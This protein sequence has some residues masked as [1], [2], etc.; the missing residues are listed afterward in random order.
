MSFEALLRVPAL[1][2]TMWT[3][4]LFAVA[5]VLWLLYRKQCFSI[6]KNMGVP[7]P[8]PS[9][10]FGNML[11]LIKKDPIKSIDEWLKKYGKIVGYYVGTKPVVL[12][13]D[14]DLLKR[15]QVSE[16]HKFVNRANVVRGGPERKTGKEKRV[17]GFSQ[18]LVALRD[19]RWKEIRSIITPS[20][21]AS[22]MKQMAPIMNS[23]IDSLVENVEKK[24]ASG[25]PFDM[26]PLFQGLTMDVIGRTAFG[27]HT[28]SQNNPND[29]LLRS[30]KVL[31]E[32]DI[33]NPLA[34]L[35]ISFRSLET[36][37]SWLGRLRL[38]VKNKGTNPLRE[39][40]ESV[41]KVIAMR[42]G[43]KESRRP[44]L[45]QLMIDAEI[46]DLKN[47][48][49]EELTASGGTDNSE[50]QSKSS[51]TNK[52]IRRM[53]D[54]D[55]LDNSVI[56]FIAAYETTSTALAFTTHLL[57]HYPEAQEKIRAEV[58]NLLDTEGNLII[59]L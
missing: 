43:K 6:L 48:T 49:T 3:V 41:K 4:T 17:E 23:A 7:G 56:F 18:H 21:T 29:P 51:S 15:I 27:I 38:T 31:L 44:D 54:A 58:Q 22:K 55:I 33:R 30:S 5:V 39:L 40:I 42:R 35:A 24:S 26:Y 36:L 12:I 28:D 19:K 1:T 9:I 25:E 16:F 32:N 34:L 59:I 13:A 2:G 52:L 37:W 14:V 57:L 10:L 20:F 53:T 8:E 47:V 11:Q 46:D 45:L 50:S